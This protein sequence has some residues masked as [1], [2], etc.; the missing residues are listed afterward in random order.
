M[1]RFLVVMAACACLASL[2]A[3]QDVRLTEDT[4][5]KEF[6]IRGKTIT[7]SRIQDQSNVLT[8]DFAK[9]SRPCPPF[10][11]H[12]MQAAPG[13]VTVGELE[14][15]DF[16]EK[17]VV[18]GDGLLIDSRVPAFFK[19]GSIPGAINVPFTTLEDSNPYRDEIIKA[20]GAV[21][22]D[23]GG[24]DFSGVKSLM[25]FCNGPW[26]DQ[27]P[28]AIRNLIAA[29]Y[30]ADKLFYYRGGMQVWRLLGLTVNQP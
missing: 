1:F 23:D 16:M 26:C 15:L 22:T 11:I 7:I 2:A 29:G 27:S 10:C 18:P 30:P 4:A 25:L 9:T 19:K 6:E 17:S 20:L 24:F 13:V 28:R 12:P 14:L 8:G 3:A 5:T 21:E